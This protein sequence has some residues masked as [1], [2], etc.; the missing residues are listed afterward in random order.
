MI[1]TMAILAL[2][3]IPVWLLY[4]LSVTGMI[5]TSSVPVWVIL[6]FT[7]IFSAMLSVV[8]K[9]KRHELVA[10]AAG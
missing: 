3:I 4:K 6:A 8:T 5:F 9:A 10:A 1:I 2:L 7:F